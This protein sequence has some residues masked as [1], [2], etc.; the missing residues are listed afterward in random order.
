[1]FDYI[2][3]CDTKNFQRKHGG[4]VII[5]FMSLFSQMLSEIPLSSVIFYQ[6]VMKHGNVSNAK[7]LTSINP[8]CSDSL[9]SLCKG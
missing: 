3:N 2:F 9:F 6:L 7:G 4:N 5:K 8:V 1:M